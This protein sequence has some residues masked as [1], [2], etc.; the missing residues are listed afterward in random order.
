MN[1]YGIYHITEAPYAY[2]EDYNNLKLN[3]ND[4]RPLSLLF[5]RD[6]KPILFILNNKNDISKIKSKNIINIIYKYDRN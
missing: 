2:A 6:N 3:N 4:T 1:K 5:E